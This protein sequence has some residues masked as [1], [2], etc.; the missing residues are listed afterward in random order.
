MAESDALSS[1]IEEALVYDM[2]AESQARALDLRL[3]AVDRMPAGYL[4]R[5]RAAGQIRNPWMPGPFFNMSAQEAIRTSYDPEVQKL[6]VYLAKQAGTPL[7]AP[8]YAAQARAEQ[9]R[10]WEEQMAQT[11]AELRASREQALAEHSA[12]LAQG[13]LKT[14]AHLRYVG[15]GGGGI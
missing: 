11:A 7:P 2:A 13:G 1:H 3:A 15:P 9:H 14:P 4:D 5:K 8:D 10:V 12:R 6:A